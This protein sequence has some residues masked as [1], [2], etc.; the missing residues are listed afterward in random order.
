MKTVL[1]A[2]SLGTS[3]EEVSAIL[4]DAGFDSLFVESCEDVLLRAGEGEAAVIID[5]RLDEAWSA[6][7]KLLAGGGDVTALPVLFHGASYRDLEDYLPGVD[8]ALADILRDPFDPDEVRYKLR[9]IQAGFE[10]FHGLLAAIFATSPDMIF[11][12]GPDGRLLDVNDNVVETYGYTRE[13]ILAAPPDMLMG[14]G[15]N[16]QE[17]IARVQRACQGEVQDFEW[18]ARGRHGEFP[19]EVRLRPLFIPSGSDGAPC[20][21]VLAVV[22]DLTEMRKI[23]AAG[24]ESE[25]QLRV[26]FDST[27]DGILVADAETKRFLSSNSTMRAMLGYSEAELAKLSVF[28][29]HPPDAIGH[30][31]DQFEKQ[32][33]GEIRIAEDL[34]VLRK[35]GG[36]FHADISSAPVVIGERQC[37]IG[38][39]RDVSHLKAAEETRR[40]NERFLSSLFASI[41]DGICVL[42]SEKRVIRVNETM[43]N[44]YRHSLPLVGKKCHEA[45]HGSPDPCP[46]CPVKETLAT[47][48]ACSATIPKRDP[49]WNVEG[50][51]ELFSYPLMDEGSGELVGVIEYV[52][53]VT[54]RKKAEDELR[55]SEKLYR[56]LVDTI[57]HGIQEIDR[58]GVI[59]FANRA[60]HRIYGYEN[61]ELI[62][63]PVFMLSRNEEEGRRLKRYVRFLL[64]EQPEPSPWTGK[65]RRKDGRLV[66][67]QVDWTYKKDEQGEVTGIISIITD[68]TDRKQQEEKLRQSQKM[69][70]IGTLAGGIAHDFNNILASIMGYTELTYRML[71]VESPWRDNLSEVLA[72]SCRARDLVKQILAFSRRSDREVRP[73]VLQPIVKEAL[74]LIRSTLPATIDI[75]QRIDKQCPPVNVDPTEMHQVIMNLCTNAYHAM[76]EKGGVL[77][78]AL[79]SVTLGHDRRA[80]D[81]VTDL[82]A[83]EYIRLKVSDTGEGMSPETCKRIFEP[84][85]TTKE[86]GK[87][88]GLGL[89]VVHGIISGHGG[90]ISVE[91]VPTEG[92][93]F[94]IYLPA[95]QGVP[96]VEQSKMAGLASGKG[97][98]ILLVDDEEVV[99]G[100]MGMTLEMLGY[101]VTTCMDGTEALRSFRDDPDSFDLVI[102]DQVMPGLLGEDLARKILDL[103]P[104]VPIILVS[105]YS[106]TMNR[107][108]ALSMGIRE[109]L[110][111]PVE[112]DKMAD[113]VRRILDKEGM[114][115]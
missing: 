68:I 37:M 38:L 49:D 100:V 95:A 84:Y 99:S 102:S 36:V 96:Q 25:E 104:R 70:A 21:A 97:E 60:F 114:G 34:P 26:I 91:S 15:E 57:P 72:A 2:G 20:R 85:F 78:V 115:D 110:L 94:S 76:G 64:E 23:A 28:D 14:A 46:V 43:E 105:G 52:R 53:N 103:R 66:D 48:R 93:T 82:P 31:F 51:F 22:R 42:D 62:G 54:E 81:G 90:R 30:V 10:G 41:H 8:P 107:E 88:T 75:R 65:G 35:D 89:S 7:R 32:L 47:G 101:R 5:S 69:E 67:I 63:K 92:S 112:M 1:I 44:W 33:R 19:V 113:I 11:V 16:P 50:W 59:R 13:E 18:T 9:K 71:P 27:S 29:I 45:F 77:E 56:L 40:K 24:R 87:G 79:D 61:G 12:H 55:A 6:G 80:G 39:F 4:A 86:Q 3:R 111:K 106:P 109:F 74:R 17:A 108:K 58:E 98:R 73:M 83:G